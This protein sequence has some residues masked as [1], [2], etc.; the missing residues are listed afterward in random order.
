MLCNKWKVHRSLS[1]P[2]RTTEVFCH[3]HLFA[4][5]Q[6]IIKTH[7][8]HK[9]NESIFTFLS[10]KPTS[11]VRHPSPTCLFIQLTKST[12]L[13]S[14]FVKVIMWQ[15]P[16]LHLNEIVTYRFR[17]VWVLWGA[18][19]KGKKKV[20]KRKRVFTVWLYFSLYRPEERASEKTAFSH[21]CVT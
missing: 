14:N 12:F 19:E 9:F 11:P 15:F 17:H 5:I 3:S 2:E 8:S 10:E 1:R 20:S 21:F 7:T 4:V 16:K 18:T 6:N 13:R